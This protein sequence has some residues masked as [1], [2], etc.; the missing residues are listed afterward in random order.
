M[1]FKVIFTA[2]FRTFHSMLGVNF[3]LKEIFC[4]SNFT[5]FRTNYMFFRPVHHLQFFLC[6]VYFSYVYF[7]PCKTTVYLV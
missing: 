1:L 5:L 4:L 6:A 3:L 7:D 2:Y